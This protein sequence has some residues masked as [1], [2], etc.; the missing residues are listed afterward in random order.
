[1]FYQNL[2]GLCNENLLTFRDDQL[3]ESHISYSSHLSTIQNFMNYNKVC[4]I[5]VVSS[6]I[7]K[8]DNRFYSTIMVPVVLKTCE[9]HLS[10]EADNLLSVLI[11]LRF[12]NGSVQRILR[13]GSSPPPSLPCLISLL[14][15][16]A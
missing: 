4:V 11:L 5:C 16:G 8:G 13:C 2:L 3:F 12:L 7:L 9:L 1:M 6:A 14:E 15:L 10:R